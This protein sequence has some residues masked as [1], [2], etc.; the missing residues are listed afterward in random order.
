MF[1][2]IITKQAIK[3]TQGRNPWI[4][5]LKMLTRAWLFCMCTVHEVINSSLNTCNKVFVKS[6]VSTFCWNVSLMH[7]SLLTAT[8]LFHFRHVQISNDGAID[9][10]RNF[11]F[12]IIETKQN[13]YKRIEPADAYVLQKTLRNSKEKK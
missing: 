2:G 6:N 3:Y 11:G 7:G 13:Y 12:E 8:I 5:F 9:F 10:Y 1:L 4:R